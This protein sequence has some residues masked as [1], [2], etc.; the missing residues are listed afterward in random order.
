KLRTESAISVRARRD[1][2]PRF[3]RIVGISPR[4]CKVR[5]DYKL[6][7]AMGAADDLGVAGAELEYALGEE[8]SAERIPIP[9]T[10]VGT[11]RATGSIVLDLHNKV[12]NG[13]RVRYRLR[14]R[15][16]RL[17]EG[18]GGP[19][20][21][22]YPSNGWFELIVASDAPPYDSQEIF[23]LRDSLGIRF[24]DL[25]REATDAAL[26][27]KQLRQETAGQSPL[28]LDHGYRINAIREG[29]R[30]SQ[31]HLESAAK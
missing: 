10:G 20:E 1:A 8:A 7:I 23:G 4:P 22:V 11:S 24:D 18:A 9:L 25:S 21:T 12:S 27:V 30:K 19:Q 17:I 16:N 14:I 15:D 13:S 29:M 26:L 28:P 31:A 2:P 3:E 6:A 5:P